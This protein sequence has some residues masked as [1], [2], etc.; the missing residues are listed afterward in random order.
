MRLRVGATQAGL[1]AQIPGLLMA[2]WPAQRSWTRCAIW[3]AGIS[4]AHIAIPSDESVIGGGSFIWAECL[5][6]TLLRPRFIWWAF[7]GLFD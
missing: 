7:R 6:T 2:A 1:V 5:T 4:D 3:Q